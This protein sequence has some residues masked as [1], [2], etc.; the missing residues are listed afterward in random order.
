MTPNMA[1]L[2]EEPA[3]TRLVFVQTYRNHFE[4]ASS[5]VERR[6]ITRSQLETLTKRYFRREPHTAEDRAAVAAHMKAHYQWRAPDVPVLVLVRTTAQRIRRG[7]SKKSAW[8]YTIDEHYRLLRRSAWG[9]HRTWIEE[10]SGRDIMLPPEPT[11]S[12]LVWLRQYFERAAKGDSV[13]R[14]VPT[15]LQSLLAFQHGIEYLLALLLVIPEYDEDRFV[16][17]RALDPEQAKSSIL[18]L[19][20]FGVVDQLRALATRTS[21]Y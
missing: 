17:F 10:L 2:L 16:R 9:Q 13:T 20:S 19:S 3:G 14:W 12:Q 21:A 8:P 7:V 18:R 5:G 4:V 1:D 6:Y 11:K 15:Y